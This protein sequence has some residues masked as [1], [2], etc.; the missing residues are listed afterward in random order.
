MSALEAFCDEQVGT[1]PFLLIGESYGGYLARALLARRAEQV[2]GLALVCP[3]GAVGEPEKRTLPRH[4]VVVQEPGLEIDEDFREVAVVQTRETLER[5]RRE[6][7]P[8]VEAADV[9]GLS[10]LDRVEL[11]LLAA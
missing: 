10:R 4:V 11:E 3:V 9:E 7:G 6:V 5:T 8:G 2:L 1:R